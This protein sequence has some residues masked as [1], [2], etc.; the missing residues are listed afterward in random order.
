MAPTL[1]QGSSVY[2]ENLE[3][4]HLSMA[5]IVAKAERLITSAASYGGLVFGGYVRDVVAPLKRGVAPEEVEF[6]D[7][8]IWFRSQDDVDRFLDN[9]PDITEFHFS[10]EPIDSSPLRRL[11]FSERYCVW[12]EESMIFYIDIVVSSHFPVCDLS[13]NLLSWDGKNLQCNKPFDALRF[14]VGKRHLP[15]SEKEFLLPNV[16]YT[17]EEILDQISASKADLLISFYLL[18]VI[19]LPGLGKLRSAS[20]QRIIQ[21][22]DRCWNLHLSG[23]PLFIS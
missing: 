22:T 13:V 16:S 15:L 17:V 12:D 23:E 18:S 8:D 6:N 14:L 10:P 21:F 2:N 1:T 11:L 5:A 9:A 7:V 3:G 19:D 20:H 4:E